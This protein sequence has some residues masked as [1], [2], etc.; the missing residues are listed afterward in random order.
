[1]ARMNRQ[2]IS[3]IRASIGT[4]LDMEALPYG[5]SGK[6]FFFRIKLSFNACHP[7]EHGFSLP[8]S[9]LPA[10]FI[11]FHYEKLADFCF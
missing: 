8:H 9:H 11:Q 10:A 2:N 7:L 3:D 6:G 5:I 1:M 4:L